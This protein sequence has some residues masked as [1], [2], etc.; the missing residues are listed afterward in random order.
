MLGNRCKIRSSKIISLKRIQTH[1]N[2]NYDYPHRF[3]LL[4]YNF[5]TEVFQI[6]DP[7][8]PAF[9]DGPQWEWCVSRYKDFLAVIFTS[10]DEDE[11]VGCFETWIVTKFDDDDPTVPSTWEHLFTI[12]PIPAYDDLWF[13]AFLFDGD[14]VLTVQGGLGASN[15]VGGHECVI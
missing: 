13:S 15:T 6:I 8:P 3:G 10:K 7:P 4:C 14:M 5:S 9:K 1:E 12:G 11:N 2:N